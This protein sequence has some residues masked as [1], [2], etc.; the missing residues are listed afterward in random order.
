MLFSLLNSDKKLINTVTKSCGSD[1]ISISCQFLL[2]QLLMLLVPLPVSFG[3][4][5]EKQQRSE[6]Q[7]C[8]HHLERTKEQTGLQPHQGSSYPS[9]QSCRNNRPQQEVRHLFR[10][11]LYV[12][13]GRN[14]QDQREHSR[15]A[16]AIAYRP[17][18]GCCVE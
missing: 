5:S 17:E 8:T 1:F 11:E 18:H 6:P 4:H 2:Q 15:T 12:E 7:S 3:H 14:R 13:L 9:G 10:P 16:Q